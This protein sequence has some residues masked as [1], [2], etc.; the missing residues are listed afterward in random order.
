MPYMTARTEDVEGP[1]FLRKFGVPF[2]A[3]AHIFGHDPIMYRLECGLGRFSVVGTTFIR[4]RCQPSL[5]RRASPTLDGEKS[6]SPRPSVAGVSWGR[7]RAG[8]RGR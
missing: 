4:R 7:A 1:L 5:G 2:W 3:L 6:T 8:S